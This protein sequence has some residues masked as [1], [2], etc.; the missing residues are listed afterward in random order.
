[1]MDKLNTFSD[2]LG[3]TIYVDIPCEHT[4]KDLL[5]L[6]LTC[7]IFIKVYENRF[8]PERINVKGWNIFK[9]WMSLNASCYLNNGKTYLIGLIFRIIY[10]VPITEN[11][12]LV[13]R[14]LYNIYGVCE[15]I[16]DCWCDCDYLMS[17]YRNMFN[18]TI[19]PYCELVGDENIITNPNPKPSIY[20]LPENNITHKKYYNNYH[21][22]HYNNYHTKPHIK[23]I[24]QPKKY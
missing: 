24:N 18:H 19:N 22:K 21:K 1:M 16:K 12:K 23:R 14:D 7:K 13:C 11:L 3:A 2:I 17:I 6:G 9:K 20:T 10:K 8:R 15:I 4:K 5:S